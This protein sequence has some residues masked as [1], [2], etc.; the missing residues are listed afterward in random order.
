MAGSPQLDLDLAVVGAGV[1]GLS[2]A[3]AARDRGLRVR[4]LESARPGSGQSAGL[5]RVFRHR[6][7]EPWLVDLAVTAR[8]AWDRW[9][10]RFGAP[11]IGDEGALLV[12]PAEVLAAHAR[13]FGV[14]GVERR[15]ITAD[16]VAEILPL[17]API[18]AG[19]LLDVRGGAMRVR[20]TV[21]GLAAA[22]EDDLVIAEVSG[23]HPDRTG[24]GLTVE[25]TEGVWSARRALVCAG[26]ATPRL[27]APLGLVLPVS[28]TWHLRGTFD[29]RADLAPTRSACLLDGGRDGGPRAY[30]GPTA[31]GRRYVLGLAAGDVGA[32]DG[33]APAA[34]SLVPAARRTSA[35]VA[36]NL[37]G[38]DPEPGDLRLCRL[39]RLPWGEDAFAAWRAGPVTAFAGHNLFKFAPVLGPLLVDAAVGDAMPVALRPQA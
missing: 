9:G 18:P 34:A 2:A 21:D 22:L 3:L 28:T 14:A 6:H 15:I 26:A 16:E 11:V 5:A 7:D 19:G 23:L 35:Y 29:V 13:R 10:E 1:I 25:T 33:D 27:V 17:S 30:G 12:G 37:P 32:A 24:A 36:R 8:E 31:D 38:L 20:E 4:C 39:T